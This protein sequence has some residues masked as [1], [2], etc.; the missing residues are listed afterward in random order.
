M[1]LVLLLL[2]SATLVR[3]QTVLD[4][5]TRDAALA[6]ARSDPREVPAEI[7]TRI[8]GL[9]VRVDVAGNRLTVHA[10]RGASVIL[11]L[12]GPIVGSTRLHSSITVLTE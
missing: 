12:V 1:L 2:Q 5:V 3:D 6:A 4:S 7:R 10:S 11:P 8:P 9:L